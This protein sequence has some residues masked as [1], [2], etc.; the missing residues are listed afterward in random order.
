MLLDLRLASPRACV[1]DE[2]EKDDPAA[3]EIDVDGTPYV[4]G[5]ISRST[6][7]SESFKIFCCLC[8]QVCEEEEMRRDQSEAEGVLEVQDCSSQASVITSSTLASTLAGLLPMLKRLPL[9][10][11]MSDE[12]RDREVEPDG[13]ADT[14]GGAAE[15]LGGTSGATLVPDTSHTP[16]DTRHTALLN[17]LISQR[18]ELQE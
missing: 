13:P 4:V 12:V 6:S 11:F 5:P 14:D 9:P 17:T 1:D 2:E 7:S 10:P 18:V 15:V 3:D 8:V 16:Y